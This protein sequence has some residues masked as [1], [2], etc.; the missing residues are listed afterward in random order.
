MINSNFFGNLNLNLKYNTLID[1]GCG[2]GH[3]INLAL[4]FK[5]EFWS[6]YC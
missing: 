3:F 1:L 2:N 6:N 5:K 4:K